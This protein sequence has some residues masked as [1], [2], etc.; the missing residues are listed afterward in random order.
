MAKLSKEEVNDR[1]DDL[2]IVPQHD[3]FP[4][5]KRLK[6]SDAVKR[7][8]EASALEKEGK[9]AKDEAGK[10]IVA[11]LAAAGREKVMYGDVPVSMV[12]G[13]SA[14][15]LDPKRLLSKGVSADVI[16]AC[17]VQGGTYTYALVGKPK[18]KDYI[19]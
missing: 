5:L 2:G 7:Y 11:A 12:E 18:E 6:F 9:A 17:T 16:A 8:Q 15:R 19:R 1:L 4:V 3:T 14:S 13:R 10:E